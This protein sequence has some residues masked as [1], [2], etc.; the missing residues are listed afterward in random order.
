MAP[1]PRRDFCVGEVRDTL[2]SLLSAVFIERIFSP[3]QKALGDHIVKGIMEVYSTRLE[4]LKWIS[5]STK[6]TAKKKC[7]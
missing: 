2:E 1:T 4:S 5:A 3:E 7:T 6:A